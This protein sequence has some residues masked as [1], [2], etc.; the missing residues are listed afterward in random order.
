[1]I[2]PDDELRKGCVESAD[3]F[4]E[5]VVSVVAA[6]L[7][8]RLGD[9]TLL[10]RDHI[11]PHP[12]VVE[13]DLRLERR[14]SVDGVAS[15]DEDVRADLAH[16]FVETHATEVRIDAPALPGGVRRPGNRDIAPRPRPLRRG[17]TPDYWFAPHPEIRKVL[18][19][20]LVEDSLV[21]G[22]A[23]QL[24]PRGEIRRLE[25]GRPNDPPRVGKRLGRRVFN[26]Q[27]RGTIR[28]APHHGAI[29]VDVARRCAER[30]R[31][32]ERLRSDD[33]RRLA[34]RFR[35]SCCD[36]CRRRSEKCATRYVVRIIEHLSL[37][38]EH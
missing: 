33:R 23:R 25:R 37:N 29:D 7:A 12:P 9:L 22:K 36:Q 8:Q 14:V 5:Q 27:P 24:E 32:P 10:G 17:K 20:D 38:I 18:E 21:F 1:M 2:I 30:R 3:V 28:S 15:M 6:E 11:A 13:R 16:G 31:G 34:K 35:R 26:D 4:V 19:S